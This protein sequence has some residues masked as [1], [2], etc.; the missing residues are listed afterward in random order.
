MKQGKKLPKGQAETADQNRIVL[1]ALAKVSIDALIDEATGYQ[2][3]RDDFELQKM[4]KAYISEETLEW[5]KTFH[6][7]F[8][9]QLYRL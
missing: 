7:S 4:L 9:E 1:G 6:D 3:V 8:Y 5:Q 2:R